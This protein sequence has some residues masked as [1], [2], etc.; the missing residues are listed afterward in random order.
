[1]VLFIPRF[2][3]FKF[4]CGAC[5]ILLYLYSI[6]LVVLYDDVSSRWTFKLI[7]RLFLVYFI[8]LFQFRTWL[9]EREG[10]T[11][12]LYIIILS[13]KHYSFLSNVSSI[14]SLHCS[15]RLE[16]YTSF[17]LTCAVQFLVL[18]NAL[19][20]DYRN[21]LPQMYQVLNFFLPQKKN[22]RGKDSW[23]AREQAHP[24]ALHISPYIWKSVVQYGVGR[25]IA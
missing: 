11:S 8:V 5:V 21:T 13:L 3:Q 17:H 18:L 7:R 25:H 1:M 16:N 4:N 2:R 10:L 14:S 20:D 6:F 24:C 15:C 9:S 23:K 22:Q 19:F 12:P